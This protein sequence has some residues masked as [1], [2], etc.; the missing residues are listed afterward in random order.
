M[1]APNEPNLAVARVLSNP[2]ILAA[3]LGAS[4][5]R[6]TENLKSFQNL[7]RRFGEDR[8]YLARTGPTPIAAAGIPPTICDA[9]CQSLEGR[10]ILL[11]LGITRRLDSASPANEMKVGSV[12]VLRHSTGLGY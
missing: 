6:V 2:D 7:H 12:C 9:P 1:G 3:I 5:L 4:S 11:D 10:E 8:S